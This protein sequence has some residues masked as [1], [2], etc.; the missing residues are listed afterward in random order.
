MTVYCWFLSREAVLTAEFF[1]LKHKVLEISDHR[2]VVM[3]VHGDEEIW[4]S[5]FSISVNDAFRHVTAEKKKTGQK[6]LEEGFLK[7]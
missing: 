2:G 4:L 6:L 7:E 5:G 1:T 3:S